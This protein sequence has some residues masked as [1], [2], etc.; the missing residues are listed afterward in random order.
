MSLDVT[1][2]RLL[3]DR[4]MHELY[5]RSVPMDLLEPHTRVL[6]KD[7]A[8]FFSEASE[9]RT[10]DTD[11]FLPWFLLAHPKLKD[12]ARAA[13]TAI[14][15]NAQASVPDAV[16]EG[17]LRR[18]EEQR[19]VANMVAIAEQYEAGAEVDVLARLP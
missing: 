9:A 18:M 6:L 19:Q 11:A 12:D 14:I 17:I 2:L 13:L 7:Y 10:A 8:K 5:H 1:L 15:R 4:Q 3:K 16:K